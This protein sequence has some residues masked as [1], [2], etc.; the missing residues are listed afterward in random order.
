MKILVNW[1]EYDGIE[2]MLPEVRQ[3]CL[4]AVG[5]LSQFLGGT[6]EEMVLVFNGKQ[7]MV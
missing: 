6:G 5:A 7:P 1:C 3:Q 2:R 4:Q